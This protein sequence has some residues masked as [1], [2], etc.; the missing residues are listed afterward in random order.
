MHFLES[1]T[2][3]GTIKQCTGVSAR[4]NTVLYCCIYMMSDT[5]EGRNPVAE[6]LRAGRPVNKILFSRGSGHHPVLAEILSLARAAGVPVES[7]NKEAL[8]RISTG[9][10]HQGVI[11]LAAARDYVTL[12]DLLDVSQVRGEPALY[13]VLDGIEDPHNLGAIIRSADASG[14]HGV[15]VRARRAAGLTAV[16]A[17]ASAGAVEYVPVARVSNIAQT[18]EALKKGDVW[19]VGI[20]AAGTVEYTDVDFT[21]PTAVVVGAEGGGLSDLVRKRCDWLTAI[22]MKGRVSSL[23]ASVA[24][25][26]VMYEALRQR[27]GKQ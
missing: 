10:A 12:A 2:G 1:G 16:V 9:R 13:C 4:R 23:N 25:A 19:V 14:F 26:L 22:P 8:D 6:A 24:A 7:V 15:V 27:S 18:I 17:K 20:D 11:A 5:I 3:S 21:L